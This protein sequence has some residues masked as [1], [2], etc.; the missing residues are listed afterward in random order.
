M[1]EGKGIKRIGG[2][3]KRPDRRVTGDPRGDNKIYLKAPAFK[4]DLFL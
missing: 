2:E 3:L 1:G 4:G